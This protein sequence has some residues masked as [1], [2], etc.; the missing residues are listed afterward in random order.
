MGRVGDGKGGGIP[1]A[2]K[3]KNAKEAKNRSRA[4]LG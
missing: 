4:L 1:K 2:A 3:K